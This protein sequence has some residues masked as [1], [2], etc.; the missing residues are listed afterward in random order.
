MMG[1][2]ALNASYDV[3]RRRQRILLLFKAAERMVLQLFEAG[4]S[5]RL[6]LE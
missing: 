1:F 2:V 6:R 4:S 5:R 3:T